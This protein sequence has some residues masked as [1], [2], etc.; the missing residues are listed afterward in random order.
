M[1]HTW[2][3]TVIIRFAWTGA[4]LNIHWIVP[5]MAG[6]P[7]GMGNC[8]VFIYATNYLVYSYDIYA[9]SALAG[10]AVLR[11][12]MGAVM[13]LAGAAMYSR[14]GP[15]WAGTLLTILEAIC[16]PI[17]FV[18]YK[19]GFKIRQKSK[20][21]RKMREEKEKQAARRSRARQGSIHSS[22]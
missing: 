9:A 20:L 22:A 12:I 10:N 21:I 18:F 17:P 13:P 4:P 7:F 1:K 16:I 11:S 15:Q 5:I 19:Y 14:L 3:L 8:A 6:I 2:V